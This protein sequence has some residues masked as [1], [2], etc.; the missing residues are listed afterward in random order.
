MVA[1]IPVPNRTSPAAMQ[2]IKFH[3]SLN[4]SDLAKSVSFYTAL[5]GA[6]PVKSYPDYAKFEI[7]V[8]PLVLSLKPKRA[9]AGGPL[10]HLGLRLVSLDQL[11][12]IHARM[13]A[14]GARIGEQDDVK[15]CYALQTKLWITDPDETLWEVY[16]LHDDVPAKAT[17]HERG[18]LACR[19]PGR[20]EDRLQ[21]VGPHARLRWTRFDRAL[22]RRAWIP[23]NAPFERSA[24]VSPG[25]ASRTI[26][27]RMASTFGSVTALSPISRARRE[28]SRRSA[29]G[30][31]VRPSGAKRIRSAAP[32]AATYSC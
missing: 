6:D 12:A 27:S 1:I 30:T 2:V 4:V 5:F 28:R 18:G 32:K 29:S 21:L 15:C 3:A 22:T 17:V 9:C 24:T 16:V 8:P 10:N 26:R 25:S 23:P 11:A 7:D 31:L 19:A 20:D 13:K 14:V